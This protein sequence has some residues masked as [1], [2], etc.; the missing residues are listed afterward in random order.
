MRVLDRNLPPSLSRFVHGHLDFRRTRAY[1]GATLTNS[2]R[3]QTKFS[4]GPLD[5]EAGCPKIDDYTRAASRLESA[6]EDPA[7]MVR[8]RMLLAQ[9]VDPFTAYPHPTGGTELRARLRLPIPSGR[10]QLP[11]TST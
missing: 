7:V 2:E 8:A 6:V 4:P 5:R 3:V 11:R 1:S 9:M 10:E